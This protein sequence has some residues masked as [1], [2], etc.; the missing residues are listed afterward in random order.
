MNELMKRSILAEGIFRISFVA[1]HIATKRRAGQFVLVIPREGGERI[2]LTIVTSDPAAGTVDLVFQVVGTTTA[3]LATL[4]VGE[5]IAHVAGPLGAATDIHNVGNVVVIG[6]GVGLAA[7]FPIA[8]AM[9]E[10]GNRLTSI[11]G[12]RNRGLVILEDDFRAISDTLFVTTDDGSYGTKGFVTDALKQLMSS[13]E[14]ID[15]VV[16]VG[17]LPMMRAVA[18]TTRPAGIKTVVS[19][20]PIMVD[21]TGM[22]GGCRVTVGGKTLFACVDG[23]EFDGHLVDFKELS[24][25]L[26]TYKDMESESYERFKAAHKCRLP[27]AS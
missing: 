25:R 13:G 2:P 21:G 9:K 12:G 18:E 6:G 5:R 19:L 3:E 20:N 27:S 10:G 4:E 22:C 16:A 23:P 8:A 1:P 14:K 7:A 15:E 17:P 11:I 26:S 24:T